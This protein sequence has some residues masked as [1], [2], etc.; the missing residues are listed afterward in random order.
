M[1]KKVKDLEHQLN[2]KDI[3]FDEYKKEM[4]KK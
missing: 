1:K 2:N 3:L 4:R